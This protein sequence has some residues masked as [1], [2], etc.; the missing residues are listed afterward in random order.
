MTCEPCQ[1]KDLEIMEEIDMFANLLM[2]IISS[3]DGIIN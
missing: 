3:M 2:T 1:Y